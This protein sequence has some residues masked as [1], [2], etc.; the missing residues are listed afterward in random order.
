MIVLLFNRFS[1]AVLAM[2]ALGAIL[3]AVAAAQLFMGAAWGATWGAAAKCLFAAVLIL[4]AFIRICASVRWYKDIPRYSGI[5]LQFKK[6]LVP[7][8]YI[9][10]IACGASLLWPTAAVLAAAALLLAVIAHVNVILIYFHIRDHSRTP[11]NF[12]SSGRFLG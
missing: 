10:A 3:A 5:E 9:M 12:Y 7:T 11:I 1:R 8:S 6:A 2:E 4:Y